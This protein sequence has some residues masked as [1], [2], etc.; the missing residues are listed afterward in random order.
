MNRVNDFFLLNNDVKE[1]YSTKERN[2]TAET[3]KYADK[4]IAYCLHAPHC[5]GI[6]CRQRFKRWTSILCITNNR[7]PLTNKSHSY[8]LKTI[9]DDF[10]IEVCLGKCFHR[11]I[12]QRRCH[13]VISIYLDPADL[14][15]TGHLFNVKT[16]LLTLLSVTSLQEATA[17]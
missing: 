11:K 2:C 1:R 5:I 8:R 13:V 14:I 15:Q 9:V 3:T 7:L 17:G 12:V 6:T 4:S 10:Y 16:R